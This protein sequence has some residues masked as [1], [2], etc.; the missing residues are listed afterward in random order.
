MPYAQVL[1]NGILSAAIVALTA[2][3]FALILSTARCFHF[4]HGAI[5][6]VSGYCLLVLDVFPGLPYFVR[7]LGAV[8]MAA[9][10]GSACEFFIYGPLRRRGSGAIALLVASLGLFTIIQNALALFFG[11]E[12]R[13]LRSHVVIQSLSF[14]GVRATTIQVTTICVALLLVVGLA[15]L[16]RTTSY[17]RLLRAVSDDSELATVIGVNVDRVI[18]WSFFLGSA[19]AGVAGIL[20]GLDGEIRPTMG[21]RPL[22]LGVV[23]AIVGGANSTIAVGLSALFLGISQQCAAWV[24][25]VQWQDTIVF[26]VLLFFLVLRPQGVFGHRNSLGHA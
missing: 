17:G 16:Q 26:A 6:A 23:A 11:D 3:G 4:A 15:V 12:A 1:F 2:A 13:M 9:A 14:H 5:F 7:L 20:V 22:L 18:L 24:L 19:L 21:M 8:G 10:I 25:P